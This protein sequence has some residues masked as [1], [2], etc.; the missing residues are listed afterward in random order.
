MSTADK[1]VHVVY[2]LRGT[3]CLLFE[4]AQQCPNSL[5]EIGSLNEHIQPHL[6][7][8]KSNLS[9]K[10]VLFFLG[11]ALD[12]KLWDCLLSLLVLLD[13]PVVQNYHTF[14]RPTDVQILLDF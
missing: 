11:G 14:H 8:L 1:P 13:N 5:V 4:N 7:I 10:T 9:A 6:I 2:Y 12:E 3:C